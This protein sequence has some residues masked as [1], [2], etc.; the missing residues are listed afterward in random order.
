MPRNKISQ[1]LINEAGVPLV[2]P[3]ANISERRAPTSGEEVASEMKGSIDL[4]LDGGTTEIG[5]SSTVLDVTT[6]PFTIL[7]EGAIPKEDLLAERHVLFI[8]TGNSCRSVMGK[9]LLEKFL[10]ESGLLDKVWVDSAGTT[11]YPGIP[12]APN[13][14][15]VM[16]E[17]GMDVS[18]HKG[19]GLTPELLKKSD[20]IFVMESIHRDIVLRTL[21]EAGS[22]VRLLKQDEGISD[23]IGKPIEEYRRIRD[24]IKA[25]V[26]DIFLELFKEEKL[27]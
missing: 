8:C 4:I 7:R 14:I 18:L 3:S 17:E 6:H 11:S 15:E 2:A 1:A 19:K 16:R 20:F 26:G 27:K 9:A 5:I 23:P 25:E 22:K 24:I 10:K 21:A 12:A 13:T